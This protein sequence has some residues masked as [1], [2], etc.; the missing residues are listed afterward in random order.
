MN[1]ARA[2]VEQLSRSKFVRD[3]LALQIGKLATAALSVLSTVIVLRALGPGEYD[4][5][6]LA[7]SFLNLLLTL[8]LTGIGQSTSTRLGIAVGARDQNQIVD[9]MAVYIQVSTIT[10]LLFFGAL[11]LLGQPAA[12][13]LQDGRREIGLLAALLAFNLLPESYYMLVVTT[14]QSRRQMRA[15][16]GLQIANQ[17]VLTTCI[18]TAVLLQPTVFSYVFAR[19]AYSLITLGLAWWLYDK[20]RLHGTP[21]FPPLGQV[22]RRARTISARPYLGFGFLNALDKN[23]ANLFIALPQQVVGAL[24]GSGVVAYLRVGLDLSAY[25]S[26]LT[27]AIFENMQAVVPQMIGRGELARLQRVFM[28]VVLALAVGG[29]LVYGALAAAAPW[30]VPLMLGEDWRPAV[31]VVQA[32]AIYGAIT[33][34]GGVFGPLYRAL[35]VMRGAIAA[36][37]AAL[38]LALPFGAW[39]LAEHLRPSFPGLPG[40]MSSI[41]IEDIRGALFGAWTINALFVIS[42]GLTAWITARALRRAA[43]AS[44]EP[45]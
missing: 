25:L 12:A 4:R 24:A 40:L 6:A 33:T 11:L 3:T 29:A 34:A 5:Y 8:D 23:L 28:R 10:A 16:A 45:T 7:F 39:L 2:I 26:L 35:D 21:P 1:T 13:L 9:L 37:A 27:S 31:P 30:L 18:I 44:A 17:L 20:L 38:A 36:K 15:L 32:L 41:I 19:V 43:Q 14:L 22:F 42:V